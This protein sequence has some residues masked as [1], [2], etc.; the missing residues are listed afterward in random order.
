MRLYNTLS[1]QLEDFVP[2]EAGHVRMYN[3]GPTV[4]GDQHVG[5]YRTF[6]FADTL[7]RWFEY[8]GWKVTQII[9]ITDVGHLTQD[10]IEAGEDKILVTARK[11]GWTA[12][13]VAEHFMNRFLAD[14]RTLG[15]REPL[16]FTRATDHVPE[17]IELIK[18]LLAKGV[19][20][21][22]K[23]NVYFDVQ[24]FAG[25][26]KLSG[27]TLETLRTNASE[28]TQ[29]EHQAEKR[30]PADFA[31]W[32]TDDK[33][34]MQWDAPWGRGFPGWHIECSA[35][36]MKYLGETLDI[37]TGGEDNIFPHHE[38]EI[39]QSE[40]VTGKPFARFWIHARHLM[41]N[42]QKISKSLG[43]VVLVQDLL[44]KGYSPADVRYTLV[45]TRYSERVNFSW[46]LFDDSRTALR[47]VLEFKRRLEDASG[48]P[49]TALSLPLERAA[50]D[51]EERMDDNLDVAGALGAL[52]TFVREGNKALDDGLAGGKARAALAQLERFDGVFG[53][54][55]GSA[56]EKAPEEVVALAR[57]RAEARQRRDFKA[58]DA[59][60]DRIKALGWSVEDTKDGAKFRRLG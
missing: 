41:W 30:H 18:V 32:K 27:N 42:G 7:R 28:R 29:H 52:H 9:N 14:R 21:A 45:R 11:M 4:Y 53:V 12:L 39:A 44:D 33:H 31:L 2:A 10:D 48:K 58:A 6:A 13:Q 20:Y 23:G 19:A 34:L 43:N 51:F 16:K 50:K 22:V 37:H 15:M 38:C 24:K 1:H 46:E 8:K 60:R 36:A 47:R 35:M 59:A 3:C 55:G 56:E 54:L 26:G 40:A 5:N 25:Y 57:E 17:M 49:E